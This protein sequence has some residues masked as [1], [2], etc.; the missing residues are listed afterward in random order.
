MKPIET[1][2][3]TKTCGT[4]RLR[5][6]ACTICERTLQGLFEVDNTSEKISFRLAD[7]RTRESVCIQ[8]RYYPGTRYLSWRIS[9]DKYWNGFYISADRWLIK[10]VPAIA[11]REKSK[12]WKPL[13]ITLHVTLYIHD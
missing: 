3:L 7:K 1:P 4:Y 13:I 10:H 5:R 9:G 2:V 12:I 6:S 8:L 11:R